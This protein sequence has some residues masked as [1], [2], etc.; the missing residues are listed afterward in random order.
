MEFGNDKF[1]LNVD[2]N[3]P[4]PVNVSPKIQKRIPP[5]IKKLPTEATVQMLQPT[6][7]PT[8]AMA[9]SKECA[10]C[11]IEHPD[12]RCPYETND[13][14]TSVISAPRADSTLSSTSN[15]DGE[16][17][18]IIDERES[19]ESTQIPLAS[20]FS[21]SIVAQQP[22]QSQS[23]QPMDTTER[24]P[25]PKV[26]PTTSQMQE[27]IT[28]RSL[29]TTSRFQSYDQTDLFYWK[30][31]AFSRQ[32]LWSQIRTGAFINPE[33]REAFL[34][35]EGTRQMQMMPS[36]PLYAPPAALSSL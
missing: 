18:L 12:G 31:T 5:P 10:R 7:Q 3:P 9:L 26:E 36:Q 6:L 13:Q 20:E 15:E 1:N 19:K 32:H 2:Y 34:Q 24:N 8:V 22:I 14:N 29:G 35:S 30:G 33:M 16:R 25:T 28:D 21:T 11:F 4:K 17:R 27:S 23:D